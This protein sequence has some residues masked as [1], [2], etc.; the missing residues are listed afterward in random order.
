ML[1]IEK[2]AAAPK[3]IRKFTKSI[4]H[5]TGEMPNMMKSL[6][7]GVEKTTDIMNAESR[8]T[9]GQNIWNKH[10]VGNVNNVSNRVFGKDIMKEKYV[11]Q[12]DDLIN[13]TRRLTRG[14]ASAFGLDPI[15]RAK[16]NMYKEMYRNQDPNNP[17][18]VNPYARS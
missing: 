5:V 10:I 7:N 16:R 18:V 4:N 2:V 13:N 1:F 17:G 12:G 6:K 9:L 15:S 11:T 14:I 8:R 3:F